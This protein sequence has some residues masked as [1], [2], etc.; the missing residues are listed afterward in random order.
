[1]KTYIFLIMLILGISACSSVTPSLNT[2]SQAGTTEQLSISVNSSVT[3]SL[4]A[5]SAEGLPGQMITIPISLTGT[6]GS[7][8]TSLSADIIFDPS[9]LDISGVTSGPSA[10]EAGMQLFKS[11]PSANLLRLGLVNFGAPRVI[12]NGVIANVSFTVRPDAK[13]GVTYLVLKPDASDISSNSVAIFAS[14]GSVL[15]KKQVLK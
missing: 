1:M 6:P 14:N 3:S 8:I 2:A 9:I 11:K 13:T 5:G 15:I 7:P 10:V 4:N 12:K